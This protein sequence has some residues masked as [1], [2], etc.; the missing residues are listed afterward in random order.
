MNTPEPAGS[1]G[2]PLASARP[3]TEPL[4]LAAPAPAGGTHPRSPDSTPPLDRSDRLAHVF[5]TMSEG[6]V[7]QDA[8]GTIYE[9]NAAAEK[10]LGLTRDQMMGVTSMDPLWR[11]VYPDGR[12]F[13]GEQHPAMV[14]LRTGQS[15]RGVEMGI[16]TSGQ[17]RRWISI[18]AE[19]LRD[20]S[21]N[22]VLVA[23]TFVDITARKTAESAL[24]TRE[25]RFRT[26]T[27][28]A[29][30]A[31][32][33]H[34]FSGRFSYV[35]QQACTS[36]GYTRDEL[37]TMSVVDLETQFDLPGAQA[38]W[39][40]I[41]PGFPF[42]LEG[43]HRR[44][45]RTTFPVEVQFGCFERDGHR[46]FIG[47]VRDITARKQAEAELREMHERLRRIGDNLPHGYIYQVERVLG[48]P[49][50]FT[51]TSAGAQSV[52][53]LTTAAVL[54]D[55]R[56]LATQVLEE[57]RQ[58]WTAAEE[59]SYRELTDFSLDLRLRV[60]NGALRWIQ[61]NSTPHKLE[62][63]TVVWDGIALDITDRKQAEADQLV[64]S[65]L[66]ATGVLAGGLAH[67]Y[68]N[69]LQVI[70]LSLD[71][72]KDPG[73]PPEEMRA[74]LDEATHAV[75]TARDLSKQLITFAAGGEPVRQHL[76]LG[77]VLRDAFQSALRGSNVAG[78]CELPAALWQ[79]DADRG[80]VEHVIN[81]LVLNAREAMPRGGRAILRIE[82]FAAPTEPT[83]AM[84]AGD[85]L[86]VSITDFGAG[87]PDE[88]LPKIFDPY[89]STKPRGAQHGMGLGLTIGRSIVERHGG[90]ITVETVVGQGTTVHLYL[91]ATRGTTTPTAMV[92]STTATQPTRGGK[93]LIMDDDSSLRIVLRLTLR[94]MGYEA[95][96]T[97]K[98]EDAVIEY[99]EAKAQGRP[100]DVVILDLTVPDG[101]GGLET[102]AE[103]RRIDPAVRAIVMSGYANN[104]ALQNW[105]AAGFCGALSKPFENTTLAQALDQALA[106]RT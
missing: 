65:K 73:L 41:R 49:A 46:N 57:D 66:A 62:N 33:V 28:Q 8:Q 100:Y 32:F 54:S 93:I 78:I 77:P 89:F 96:A 40:R 85:Y 14:A 7:V 35:N 95:T 80:Q 44:K 103:L 12:P 13:P 34:D 24:Q 102:L 106:P 16:D 74:C 61:L 70:L 68:N 81:N 17:G 23:A 63:G 38:A 31:V 10:I 4:S 105:N 94:T 47:H 101:M 99:R 22:V 45:D 9:C 25:Q 39:S 30:D 67:D 3:A 26:Y 18:N 27:E 86:H 15:V 84:P 76:D 60:S 90:V 88:I 83:A 91:P 50:R 53:G 36:L 52:H 1:D 75:K 37:L 64:R 5:Q 48:Q 56:V 97:A 43:R 87:I 55:A 59:K 11:A 19:P 20:S 6:L 2:P 92:P 42:N 21:G 71:A 29:T 82:N 98:G 72:A 51:F 58:A 104:S 69:L 79:V